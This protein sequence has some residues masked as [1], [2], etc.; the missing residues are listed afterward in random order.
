MRFSPRSAPGTSPSSLSSSS[1]SRGAPRLPLEEGSPDGL[2]TCALD[3]LKLC[4]WACCYPT[5]RVQ[6]APGI[7][8]IVVVGSDVLEGLR[9]LLWRAA[10]GPRHGCDHAHGDEK[11]DGGTW[12][13]GT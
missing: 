3:T 9:N 11:V 13:L 8:D 4:V 10:S 2:Q 5:S 6:G 12:P 7:V 1:T